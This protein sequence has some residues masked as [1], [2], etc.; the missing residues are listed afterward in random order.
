MGSLVAELAE[1][2]SS[3]TNS[4]DFDEQTLFLNTSANTVGVGT[5][6]PASKF[7]VRGTMQVGLNDTG[8]DVQFFGDAAGAA[9]IWD[10]SADSLLVRGATADAVGSSGRIVLQTAQVGVADGDILGRIDFQ[11]PL[12][13]QGGDGALVSAAIWAE[14]DD[15]FTATVNSTEL[16]FATAT[17]D[18]VVERMRVASDGKVGI[19]TSVPLTALTVEGTLTLKE[20]SAAGGDT[21][22]YGQIWVDDAANSPLMFTNDAGADISITTGSTLNAASL[23]GA[24]PAGVTGGAGLTGSTSLGTVATGVWEA[25]DVAVAH[26]GTGASTAAAA[27]SALGLGTGNTPTFVALAPTRSASPTLNLTNGSWGTLW[28]TNGWTKGLY[29]YEAQYSTSTGFN[30]GFIH[31]AYG[32]QLSF[33]KIQ[34]NYSSIRFSGTNFQIQSGISWAGALNWSGSV[35]F[36]TSLA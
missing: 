31:K 22:A 34:G 17:D 5:N 19:G 27:A 33:H 16:V 1:K 13:T 35:W 24:V 6:A 30:Y 4:I 25:T 20:Q 14:A 9:M 32:N 10:T 26:G 3:A 8:Y 29:L 21:A 7:D 23:G 36:L 2:L 12:E 11:A 15:T 28:D 18:A